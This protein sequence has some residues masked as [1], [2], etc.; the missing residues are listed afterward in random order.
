[1]KHRAGIVFA[2]V[3]VLCLFTTGL[4]RAQDTQ[5]APDE[6]PPFLL[7]LR[8]SGADVRFLGEDY[9]IYSWL[10]T[11]QGQVQFFYSIPGGDAV[12]SGGLLIGPDGEAITARRIVDLNSKNPELAESVKK[13]GETAGNDK[14]A[15]PPTSPGERFFADAEGAQWFAIG[16]EKAPAIYVFIDTQC[17]Y[18]RDYWHDLAT[19]YVDEGRL[20]VRLIPVAIDGDKS[21]KEAANLLT[22]VDPATTWRRHADGDDSVL[23]HGDTNEIAI[24]AIKRNTEI[25]KNWKLKSTPYSVYRDSAGEVKVMRGMKPGVTAGTVFKD[26]T[27]QEG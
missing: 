3:L 2:L 7:E 20:Q 25:F 15:K 13:S 24:E 17:A 9:G 23:S 4:A 6:L 19:P 26:L 11:K 12:V 27:G 14:T 22:S 10:A 21:E 18:C 5:K 1:M 8:V 16:S